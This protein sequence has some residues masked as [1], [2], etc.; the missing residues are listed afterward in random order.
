MSVRSHEL[1]P[2]GRCECGTYAYGAIAKGVEIFDGVKTI[3][4]A[5]AMVPKCKSR[6]LL[7]QGMIDFLHGCSFPIDGK[8]ILEEAA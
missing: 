5:I 8:K 3:E 7:C 2:C 4:E 6:S 1:C